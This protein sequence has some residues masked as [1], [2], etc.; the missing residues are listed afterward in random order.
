MTDQLGTSRKGMMSTAASPSSVVKP[1][2]IE[3]VG[4]KIKL[5][6]MMLASFVTL[7]TRAPDTTA[8]RRVFLQQQRETCTQHNQEL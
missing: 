6:K 8:R 2:Y 4:E 7:R 3:P 1:R 5:K